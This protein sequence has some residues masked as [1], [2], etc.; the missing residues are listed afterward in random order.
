MAVYT[1]ISAKE[2]ESFVTGFNIGNV[3][4][5]EGI[6][7]GTENSNFILNTTLGKFVLTLYEKRVNIR[8]LPFFLG[9]IHYLAEVGFP[10]PRPISNRAGQYLHSLAG[11][12]AALISFAI[13]DSLENPSVSNCRQMGVAAA[14]LHSSAKDFKMSRKNDQ[15]L[16]AWR[17][18]FETLQERADDI[19]PGFAQW[20][21][22]ELAALENSYPRSLPMGIIHGDLFPD[23]VFFKNGIVSAVIDFYFACNDA[24]AFDLAICLNAWCFDDSGGLDKSLSEALFDGYQSVRPLAQIELEALPLLARGAA[25]RFLI[26]RLH[27][28]FNATDGILIQKKDPLAF[29]PIIEFHRKTNDSI[30]YGIG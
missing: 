26:T 7:Q 11:R 13:G 16:P 12:P 6:P 29:V 8:D 22:D 15:C 25:M 23:N 5:C 20:I 21:E 1:Q 2:L 14:R 19:R 4:S 18:S 27:D 3:I 28:W 10:C 17:K 9:L 24:Y 30:A